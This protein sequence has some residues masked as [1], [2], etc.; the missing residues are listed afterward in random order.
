MFI[1]I[2]SSSKDGLFKLIDNNI[3]KLLEPYKSFFYEASDFM[4]SVK[5]KEITIK[6]KDGIKLNGLFIDNKK[7]KYIMI[8][9]HGYR[10]TKERDIYASLKNYYEMGFSLLVLDMRGCGKSKSKYI[11]FGYKEKDDI[12]L[13]INY[14][15]KKYRKEILLAGVSLG[16]SSILLVNNPHV[17]LMLSDSSYKN[18]YEEIKYV[19]NHYYHVPSNLFIGIISFYA[20]IFIGIDI[21]DI[22][23]LNNLDKINIPILFVHGKS[24]HFVPTSNSID[25]YD[26]YKHD[27]EILLI[28]DANH[29]MSYLLDKKLYVKTIKDFLKKYLTNT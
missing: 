23:V 2:F 27:K 11:T 20:K 6:S 10:S 25:L 14:L 21:K 12:N 24:D 8:L 15:Y 29:G 19:I 16:A 4:K 17:K 3:N 22:N 13:W 26:Y 28:D 5:S 9:C 18:A 1:F 7:S